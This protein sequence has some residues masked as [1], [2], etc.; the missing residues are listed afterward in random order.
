MPTDTAQVWDGREL[1]GGSGS[2]SSSWESSWTPSFPGVWHAASGPSSDA[3]HRPGLRLYSQ[4]H[5]IAQWHTHPVSAEWH[6]TVRLHWGFIT[7]FPYAAKKVTVSALDINTNCRDG[8]CLWGYGHNLK[9]VISHCDQV[10]DLVFIH[11]NICDWPKLLEVLSNVSLRDV[12]LDATD[13]HTMLLLGLP[14]GSHSAQ[15]L[16][17]PSFNMLL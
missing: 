13:K 3:Q 4:S 2:H 14:G 10:S 8:H 5:W 12:R 15:C 1:V 9:Q 16:V 6:I 17:F 11:D 7:T